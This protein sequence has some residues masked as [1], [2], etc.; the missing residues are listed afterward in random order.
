MSKLTSLEMALR[1]L[2]DFSVIDTAEVAPPRCDTCQ[3]TGYV[4][5]DVPFGHPYFGRM[6]ECDAPGCPVVEEHHRQRTERIMQQST[7]DADYGNITFASFSDLVD[8]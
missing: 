5:Y 1:N 4:R 6:V 2:P 7:W 8:Q 3:D